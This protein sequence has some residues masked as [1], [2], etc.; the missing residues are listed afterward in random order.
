MLIQLLMKIIL[1]NRGRRNLRTHK[2]WPC[3]IRMKNEDQSD[4]LDLSNLQLVTGQN[5]YFKIV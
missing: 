5:L 1:H 3:Q 4:D 2:L